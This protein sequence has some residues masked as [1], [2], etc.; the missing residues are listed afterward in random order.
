MMQSRQKSR[1]GWGEMSS[2]N[3]D[4]T[5]QIEQ[6][7]KKKEGKNERPT[8][9]LSNAGRQT[10][11]RH[12]LQY[13]GQSLATISNCDIILDTGGNGTINTLDYDRI[14]NRNEARLNQLR[15]LGVETI[16][17]NNDE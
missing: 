3:S 7:L 16:N 8:S 5:K 6:L 11:S 2:V 9:H 4:I 12:G 10:L 1:G 13:E 15:N 17:T 14:H